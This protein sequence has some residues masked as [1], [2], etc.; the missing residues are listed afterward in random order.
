MI[1]RSAFIHKC[2]KLSSTHSTHRTMDRQTTGQTADSNAGRQAGRHLHIV[3][4][5]YATEIGVG[6]I[7][8]TLFE[9]HMHRTLLD[10]YQ[11]SEKTYCQVLCDNKKLERKIYI[12]GWFK[13]KKSRNIHTYICRVFWV[14][15]YTSHCFPSTE[16]LFLG[17]RFWGF[18][19]CVPK[20][21]MYE[22][23]IIKS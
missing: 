21:K 1:P 23:L 17:Q 5:A 19:Y 11:N 8:A 20:F 18:L 22:I 6:C 12:N 4:T 7:Y 10:K 3:A 16:S 2:N 14:F 15:Q 9:P 13:I